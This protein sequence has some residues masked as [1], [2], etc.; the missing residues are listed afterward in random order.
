MQRPF[1][2]WKIVFLPRQNQLKKYAIFNMLIIGK[3]TYYVKRNMRTEIALVMKI[4]VR[5]RTDAGQ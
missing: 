3:S 4:L 5:I 1:V 2:L